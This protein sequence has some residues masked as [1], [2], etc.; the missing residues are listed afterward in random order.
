MYILVGKREILTCKFSPWRVKLTLNE[1]ITW[2]LLINLISSL[3]TRRDKYLPLVLPKLVEN[4][5]L[6]TCN[7]FPIQVLL[8][9]NEEKMKLKLTKVITVN[10]YE[11]LLYNKNGTISDPNR[12]KDYQDHYRWDTGSRQWSTWSKDGRRL[13]LRRYRHPQ[14]VN[15]VLKEFSEALETFTSL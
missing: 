11:V 10:D 5:H 15:L 12:K 1:E 3:H 14:P 9:L 2:F 6:L 8:I 7:I 4:Y 13:N